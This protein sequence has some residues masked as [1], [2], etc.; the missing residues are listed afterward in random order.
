[1]TQ[2]LLSYPFRRHFVSVGIGHFDIVAENVVEGSVRERQLPPGEPYIS[3][4][5]TLDNS[6]SQIMMITGPNMSGKSALL[7]HTALTISLTL[8]L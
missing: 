4:S 8:T 3:N 6:S 2:C 1:M 7:R 5:V